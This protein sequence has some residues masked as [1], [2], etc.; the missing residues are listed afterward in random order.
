MAELKHTFVKG[1]MNKDLDERLIPNGEYRDALNVQ[2]SNSEGSDVGSLEN[3]LGNIKVSALGLTNATAIGAADDKLNKK[4]YWFITSDEVDGIYEYDTTTKQI[5]PIVVDPKTNSTTTINSLVLRSNIDNHLVIDN[6]SVQEAK[7]LF[8]ISDEDF[9]VTSTE[10]VLTNNNVT[11]TVTAPE[12]SVTIPRNTVMMLDDDSGFL[13]KNINYTNVDYGDL[14]VMFNYSDSSVLGFDKKHLIT[15]TNVLNGTLYFTDDLNEPRAINIDNFRRYSSSLISDNGDIL[16][17]TQT[18]VK[19]D[20]YID[21][22]IKEPFEREFEEKDINLAKKSPQASP[23]LDLKDTLRDGIISA[24]VEKNLYTDGVLVR[25]DSSDPSFS[26]TYGVLPDWRVGD[27]IRFEPSNLDTDGN[28]EADEWE[29]VAIIKEI[30]IASKKVTYN[31]LS[32]TSTPKDKT[33][34]LEQELIQD[35]PIYELKFPRFAYRWKYIDNTYSTFSPFTEVA[36][37]PGKFE[38]D[39]KNA[40][41]EGLVNN[42]RKIKLSNIDLGDDTVKEID[43]LM[44]DDN[45]NNVYVVSNK[46]KSNFFGSIEI[47]KEQIK[48]TVPNQQLLRQ[49]DNVPK[50]AKS[51]EVVANR[52]IYGNYVQN[53]NVYSKPM[54]D[55]NINKRTTETIASIK[56]DRSYEFGVVYVDEYNRQTPVL[57]GDNSV[58]TVPKTSSVDN[59]EFRVKLD[60]YAPAWAKHFKYFIKETSNEYY[61]LAADRFYPDEENGFTY[62]SFPSADRNKITQ[63]NYVILKKKHGE[64]SAVLEQDNRYKIIDIFNEAPEFVT[65]RTRPVISM[66]NVVFTDD[67]AGSGGG[68]TITNKEDAENNAPIKDFASI[69]IKEVNESGDGVSTDITKEIKKGRYASFEYLGKESGLYKIKNLSQHPSGVNE[70]RIDFDEP[71]KE[72]VEIIYQKTD[73]N[74]GDTTTNDGVNITIHEEYSAAG[75]KEFDGRFFVKLRTNS[76][77]E[78]AIVKQVI[79]D[80]EYLAKESVN[81]IGVYSVN[82]DGKRN[83]NGYNNTARGRSNAHHGADNEFV[84]SHGGTASAGATPETGQRLKSGKFEYNISL[85]CATHEMDGVVNDLAKKAKIGNFVRF[86]NKDGTPHHDTVYEIGNVLNEGFDAKFGSSNK[87]SY[88]RIS[89]RFID[90]EGE[91]KPLELDVVKRGDDTWGDEPQMEILEERNN[92]QTIVKDPAIFETEPLESKTDL[93]IYFETEKAYDISE[94]GQTQV[95]KWFNCFSFKN[96]VE[97]NRIRDDYNAPFIKNGVKASTILEEG[98]NEE[99]VFN[100]L[101]WSGIVNPNSAINNSNQF[102]QAEPITKNFLPSYGKIQKLHAWDDSLVVFTENK[103]LRTPANKSA[104]YNA[105]GSTNLISTNR[106]IGDAIEYNGDFGISNDPESFAAFGFRCYFVD[107]R[108]GKVIRLSK[109]GLTAISAVNMNDF[110]RDRLSTSQSLFGSYDERNKLYNL[111][112]F[113]DADTVCFSEGVNGWPTRKS[114]VPQ[115]AISLNSIYYTFYNGELWEHD[116]IS[117]NRNNFY[118][119]DYYSQVKLEIND[120]PSVIK[121]YKTLAY[122]GSKDWTADVVTDQEKSS[123]VTFKDKENKYFANLNGEVKEYSST[124]DNLDLKKFNFQGIGR[125]SVMDTIDDNRVDTTLKFIAEVK[126]LSVVTSSEYKFV[127]KPGDKINTGTI[128]LVL[129]PP[130]GFTLNASDFAQITETGYSNKINSSITQ[131]GA[132]VAIEYTHGI[133]SQPDTD[134]TI[135]ILLTGKMV[136]NDIT[137]SGKHKQKLVGVVSSIAKLEDNYTITGKPNTERT[138][139]NRVVT[140]QDGYEIYAN[141]IS[142]DNPAI[143]LIITEL[144]KGYSYRIT[145]KTVIP[146]VTEKNRDYQVNVIAT[147]VAIPNKKI[148]SRSISTANLGYDKDETRVLKITGEQGAIVKYKFADTS[149]TI[150][151][152]TITIQQSGSIDIPLVFPAG[153]TA[154]TYTITFSSGA[155]TEFGDNWQGNVT[156]KRVAKAVKKINITASLGTYSVVSSVSSNAGQALIQKITMVIDAAAA[157]YKVLAYPKASDFIIKDEDE[158]NVLVFDGISL[159]ASTPSGGSNKN[160]ITLTYFISTTSV[161]HNDNV[162]IDLTKFVGK[163]IDLTIAYNA[164][165][166]GGT[167]TAAGSAYTI[168]PSTSHSINGVAGL[169]PTTESKYTYTLTIALGKELI[170]TIVAGDFVLYDSSNN[171]VTSTYNN[172]DTLDIRTAG[173]K[174]YIDFKPKSFNMPTSDTTLTIRPTKAIVQTTVASVNYSVIA[175]DL[176]RVVSTDSFVYG[177]ELVSGKWPIFANKVSAKT[178]ATTGTKLIQFKYKINRLSDVFNDHQKFTKWSNSDNSIV[179]NNGSDTELSLATSGTYA[180]IQGGDNITVTGGFEV[181]NDASASTSTLTVNILLNTANIPSGKTVGTIQINAGVNIQQDVKHKTSLPQVNKP[182]ACAQT[183]YYDFGYWN[184]D[185]TRQYPKVGA[186]VVQGHHTASNTGGHISLPVGKLYIKDSVVNKIY[187]MNLDTGRIAEIQELCAEEPNPVLIENARF[188]ASETPEEL[189]FESFTNL[190]KPTDLYQSYQAPGWMINSPIHLVNYKQLMSNNAVDEAGI[191]RN[192]KV[193]IIL[194]R[195]TEDAIDKYLGS[196]LVPANFGGINDKLFS[197]TNVDATYKKIKNGNNSTIRITFSIDIANNSA[198]SDI[199][200]LTQHVFSDMPTYYGPQFASISFVNGTTGSFN[201][202]VPLNVEIRTGDQ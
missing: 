100:G 11:L 91:F 86:V 124:S 12:I 56:S 153:S 119:T 104:L 21:E 15:G 3:I 88:R 199:S 55:I 128:T 23:T 161:D 115:C 144:I 75:D 162:F 131:R 69:Q 130:S 111:S 41:N 35:K 174:V 145:E 178:T 170:P 33:Y 19:G 39:G 116:S 80:K 74:L 160:R 31:I 64:N 129:T 147:S 185:F 106:V 63:D 37:L 146:S 158:N 112:F 101:I 156:I 2:V 20:I 134:Q 43:I 125:P 1:R 8:N 27:K 76:T 98:Y 191:L 103:V 40:Y 186:W 198:Q 172:D 28:V 95:L 68:A 6:L 81:L 163:D 105:D 179:F 67:Y 139:I 42:V 70:I 166:T 122:E 36:F 190:L 136:Q 89:F 38:Y 96:G 201:Y 66:G 87:R 46:K 48:S 182:T 110:F 159:V 51:Q 114:F 90:D 196:A 79:G 61:N 181:D 192:V 82:E 154:E 49:W 92:E 108:N 188:N 102:I 107:R 109:D 65:N 113:T 195:M 151:E 189:Y 180:P 123:T 45:D 187:L 29:A 83:N 93:N 50:R 150:E 176:F 202:A 167:D 200:Y 126:G 10:E 78:N 127:K 117:V 133:N 120:D 149:N 118:G 58:I 62:I 135:K 138:I 7:D 169:V 171:D 121:K 193:D 177:S 168:S 32:Y 155:D 141:N 72:D 99:R 84:V 34:L 14:T 24:I 194:Q 137:L 16:K 73:G 143:K 59:N 140:V 132:G 47:T 165:T 157:D 44:K 5:S 53:Y 25:P 57:S 9:P 97:S 184:T 18:H 173:D 164:T 71:F 22:N 13:F 77:L 26:I 94:H 60:N 152:D 183:N 85:E 4:L 148:I 30:L 175:T 54:F 52:I 142:T 197:G 17:D